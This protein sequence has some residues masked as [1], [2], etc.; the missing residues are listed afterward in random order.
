[1]LD[2]RWNG[3]FADK[4]D[5]FAELHRQPL[6]ALK[7]DELWSAVK[8]INPD[9]LLANEGAPQHAD[10]LADHRNVELVV[11]LEPVYDVLQR[12]VVA[13]LETVPQRPLGRAVL[14]LRGGDGFREAKEG[15]GKI[16]K[17]ILVLLQL[18]LAVNEL[19]VDRF[20]VN[21]QY[22]TTWGIF[23]PCRA[24]GKPTQSRETW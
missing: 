9:L 7:D 3:L 2:V 5:Q 20:M 24:Q 16:D 22:D 1:M 4:F 6:L 14:E 18:R 23:L 19:N 8:L 15:E 21:D 17:S 11:G 13:E 12:R 10:T